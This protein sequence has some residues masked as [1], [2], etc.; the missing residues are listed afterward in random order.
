MATYIENNVQNALT[1]VHN[2]D[3]I[4]TTATHYRVLQTTLYNCLK[5]T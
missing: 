2:K 5:G 4:A 1:N 3:T